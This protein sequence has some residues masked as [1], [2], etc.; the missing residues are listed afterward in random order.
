MVIKRKFTKINILQANHQESYRQEYLES[1]H[2]QC[3][4][5]LKKK[6]IFAQLCRHKNYGKT[7]PVHLAEV[8]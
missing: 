4:K 2:A 6:G 3:A 8:K 1:A 5:G 7:F